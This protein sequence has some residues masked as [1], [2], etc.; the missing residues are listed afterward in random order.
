MA[1]KM[2]YYF[3]A[4]TARSLGDQLGIDGAEYAKWVA[5][6]V[7]D[8]EIL[9]RVTVFAA[10]LRA[11]LPQDYTTAVQAVVDKLGPEL[12]EGE[13]YF[14][15]AFHLWPVSRYI[16]LYGLDNPE[17]SLT[18]I[19]ALTRAFT[20]EWAVRPYLERYPDLTMR[21]VHAWAESESH[22]VRRLASEGIRPRLPWARVHTPFVADPSPIIPVL[23]TLAAD[24]SLFVR[25]SVA[26]NLNDITRTHPELA[27]E[28]ARRWSA[29][30]PTA[31]TMWLIERGVRTLIKQGHP[32]ALELVGFIQS[33]D[34]VLHTVDFPDR[35][36]VG[37]TGTLS[38]ELKNT[39]RSSHELLVEYRMHFLKK[40]G[41]RRPT[42]FRIGK[43]HLAPG[44][45][46]LVNK[47]HAFRITGTRTYYPG[48]QAV[49]VVVNGVE[50]PPLPFE[51]TQ[52]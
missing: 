49:S 9:D 22:N 43:F 33:D 30:Y 44:E 18:A 27:L 1:Q 36:A 6:R 35:V 3:N 11:R 37:E 7:D 28:T 38:A 24:T 21:R 25:K 16:E 46:L 45:T 2:K 5:P 14:N 10:G 41:Q 32:E 50:S 42:V 20:G 4:D 51:L 26:N 40:H 8:L 13:G 23:D 39:G 48:T 31:E 19:E 29:T 12:R 47:T 15:H 52:G 34:V 17:L